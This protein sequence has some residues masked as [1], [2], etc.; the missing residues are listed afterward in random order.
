MHTGANTVSG[1]NFLKNHLIRIIKNNFDQSHMAE[2]KYEESIAGKTK[3][4]PELKPKFGEF[5]AERTKLRKQRLYEIAKK[6]K[7]I[8]KNLF[9]QYFEYSSPSDMYKNLNTTAQKKTKL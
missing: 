2:Q 8:N 7:M 3:S 4:K 5:I 1:K 6:E 9:K